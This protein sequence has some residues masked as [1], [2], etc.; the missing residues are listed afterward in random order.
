MK[1][2]VGLYIS[3]VFS[4]APH[5]FSLSIFLISYSW[6]SHGYTKRPMAAWS[7][8]KWGNGN[9]SS[10]C[11]LSDKKLSQVIFWVSY[12]PKGKINL[13]LAP[14]K[15]PLCLLILILNTTIFSDGYHSGLGEASWKFKYM[16]H[17]LFWWCS[18]SCLWLI[19]NFFKWLHTFCPQFWVALVLN[20]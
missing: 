10:I 11:P 12:H 6:S 1:T 15:M 16:W 4:G 18:I 19:I 17:C 3:L 20:R 9:W 7:A 13:I 5:F 2:L 8:F 14:L